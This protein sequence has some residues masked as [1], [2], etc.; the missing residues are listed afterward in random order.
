MALFSGYKRGKGVLSR[1]SRIF[2][3]SYLGGIRGLDY[4]STRTDYPSVAR[5]NVLQG[6]YACRFASAFLSS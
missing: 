4:E 2:G 6:E 1:G 3:I 5:I